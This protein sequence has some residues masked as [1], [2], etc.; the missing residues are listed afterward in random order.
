LGCHWTVR[1][2]HPKQRNA[3]AATHRLNVKGT[4]IK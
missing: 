4:P 2:Q 1:N 3:P